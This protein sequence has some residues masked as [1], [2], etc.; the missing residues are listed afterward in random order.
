MSADHGPTAADLLAH[1]EDPDRYAGTQF[2]VRAVVPRLPA[3]PAD[4]PWDGFTGPY[5]PVGDV[6]GHLAGLASADPEVAD[7]APAGLWRSLHHQGTVY[8]SAALA[9]PFLLRPAARPRTHDRQGILALVAACARGADTL[10]PT[11]NVLWLT[12]GARGGRAYDTSG[13]LANWSMEAV[14]AAVTAHLGVLEPLLDDGDPQVR[15]MA[16]YTLAMASGPAPADALRRRAG[17][18]TAPLAAASLVPAAAQLAHRHGQDAGPWLDAL[19]R[20]PARPAEA[21]VAAALARLCFEEARP[22]PEELRP[23]LDGRLD[24]TL[25]R[26]LDELP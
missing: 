22:A 17:T 10:G 15:V 1:E 21:A 12:E 18:G 5:G 2:D 20:D 6:P 26:A 11:E 9:A 19:L 14:Q 4:A 13:Y 16:A 23:V 24:D 8:A 25:L 7:E 3:D